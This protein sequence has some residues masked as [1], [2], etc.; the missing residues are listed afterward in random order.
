VIRSSPVL[1]PS[2]INLWL[3]WSIGCRSSAL[4][5]VVPTQICHLILRVEHM[6][7]IY[8]WHSCPDRHPLGYSASVKYRLNLSLIRRPN[9]NKYSWIFAHVYPLGGKYNFYPPDRFNGEACI[10]IYYLLK[11][12]YGVIK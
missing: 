8:Q 1:Q 4:I 11:V 7:L 3:A 9:N 2:S 5:S 6:A 10:N 12:Q